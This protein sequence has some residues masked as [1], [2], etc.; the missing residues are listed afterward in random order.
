VPESQDPA[1]MSEEEEEEED[2]IET[3]ESELEN[4]SDDDEDH[5]SGSES[6]QSGSSEKRKK[7]EDAKRK[8][9]LLKRKKKQLKQ[10]TEKKA[11][12]DE[13]KHDLKKK[14]SKK[15]EK[16]LPVTDAVKPDELVKEKH[17][18]K[19]EGEVKKKSTDFSA[20][21]IDVNLYDDDPN[22]LVKKSIQI[23]KDTV[24][25]CRMITVQQPRANSFEFAAIVFTRKGKDDKAFEFNLP[26]N[27]APRIINALNLMI[28]HNSNFFDKN[29]NQN[30]S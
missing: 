7:E 10:L 9:S 28:K 25:S 12:I 15:A 23:S 27:L 19:I 16:E 17:A 1:Y 18:N 6:D 3:D 21:N 13:S 14:K 11:K 2:I 22:R 29:Q 20:L 30:Q 8:V 26:L 5:T 4:D 24:V